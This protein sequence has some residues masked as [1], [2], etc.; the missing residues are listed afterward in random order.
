MAEL[1]Q[2]YLRADYFVALGRREWH[3]RIGDPVPDIEEVLQGARYLFI[4]AW[5]PVSEDIG[6][7]DNIEADQQLQARL[8]QAGFPHYSALGGDPVGGRRE[9]GWLVLDLP[10]ATA[11][12]LAGEF[13]QAG[14]VYWQRGEP[15]RLR[16]QSAQ[17]PD[18]DGHDCVDWTG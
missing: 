1:A 17:P 8:Q 13:R 2:I 11:D 10:R 5:N 6:L 3:F 12:L 16:M 15:V 14:V 9:H 18:W 7:D 4:T